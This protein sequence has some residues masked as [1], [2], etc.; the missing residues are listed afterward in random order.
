[1]DLSAF[2]SGARSQ[3]KGTGVKAKWTQLKNWLYPVT[4]DKRK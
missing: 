3:P 2:H 4:K 1:M